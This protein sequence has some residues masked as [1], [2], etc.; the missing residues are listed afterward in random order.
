MRGYILFSGCMILG[1]GK[2][3]EGTI[4][5]REGEKRRALRRRGGRGGGRGKEQ[6]R[7]MSFI[8]FLV[9]LLKGIFLFLSL[10][11]STLLLPGLTE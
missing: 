10:P 3:G 9:L 1:L 7:G 2:R 5:G 4:R 11:L 6:Q 8:L